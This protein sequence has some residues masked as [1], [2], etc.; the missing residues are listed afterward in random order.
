MLLS[1][2]RFF[3]EVAVLSL[4]PGRHGYTGE[5]LQPSSLLAIASQLAGARHLFV[6]VRL[7]GTFPVAASCRRRPRAL[8][9]WHTLHTFLETITTD[10]FD[11]G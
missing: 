1:V 3:L 9:P 2:R 8:Q 7:T 11:F 10:A 5:W 6:I 4:R